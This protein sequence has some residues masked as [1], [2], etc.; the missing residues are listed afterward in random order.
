MSV[1]DLTIKQ[2][3]QALELIHNMTEINMQHTMV[4]VGDPTHDCEMEDDV[5]DGFED[6]PDFDA[7][8]IQVFLAFEQSSLAMCKMLRNGLRQNGWTELTKEVGN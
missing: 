6:M 2:L 7:F 8:D 1:E 5:D 3:Q 4:I